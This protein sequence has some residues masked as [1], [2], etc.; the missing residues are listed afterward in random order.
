MGWRWVQILVVAALFLCD[1]C[2]A[3]PH[4]ETG[5]ASYYRPARGPR[6]CAAHRRLPLGTRVRVTRRGNGR[7]VVVT[8]SDRGPFARGR[9]LDLSR[10]AAEQLQMIRVGVAMVELEVLTEGAA[11]TLQPPSVAPLPGRR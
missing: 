2:E 3:G 4:R 5:K 10:A 11:G 9:I 1:F 6:F 7:S 8:I